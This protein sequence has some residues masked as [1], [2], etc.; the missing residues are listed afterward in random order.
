MY[1]RDPIIPILNNHIDRILSITGDHQ[2]LI[3]RILDII[4]DIERR[5]DG[6]PPGRTP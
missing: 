3:I 6:D 4:E 5:L 2:N 1:Y